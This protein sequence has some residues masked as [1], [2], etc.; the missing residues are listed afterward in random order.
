LL[1]NGRGACHFNA[2]TH[3]LPGLIFHQFAV[4]SNSIE[5]KFRMICLSDKLGNDAR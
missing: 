2:P 4:R 3:V 1:R 5:V